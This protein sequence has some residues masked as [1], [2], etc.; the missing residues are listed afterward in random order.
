MRTPP[1]RAS[2]A[3]SCPPREP[4]LALVGAKPPL[5]GPRHG[6]RWISTVCVAAGALCTSA[7]AHAAGFGGAG[8]NTVYGGISSWQP[9]P[10]LGDFQGMNTP[11]GLNLNLSSASMLGLGFVH[12]TSDRWSVEL[13]LGAAPTVHAR[14]RGVNW[15]LL[16]VVEGTRIAD[17]D[18]LSPTVFVNWHLRGR[19][20]RWDPFVGAGLNYTRFGRPRALAPLVQALGPS[21]LSLSDGWGVAAH[22]GLIHHIDSHWSLIASVS[23]A[24]VR[25]TLTI[26]SYA[27]EGLSPGLVTSQ[28]S[29]RIAFRPAAY[30][31]AV[32]YSF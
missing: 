12:D 18:V 29:T 17:V 15:T 25:S 26:I 32:G 4:S 20:A 2:R 10:L 16:G 31:L 9:R 5:R 21:Q 19:E 22:A 23:G 24:E 3:S 30:T 1:F 8:A 7:V 11:P 14:A 28:S 13:A 27:A 6:R